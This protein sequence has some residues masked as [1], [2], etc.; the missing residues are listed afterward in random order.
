MIDLAL[1]SG[2]IG[3]FLLAPSQAPVPALQ[4]LPI[5]ALDRL[6][7]EAQEQVAEQQR[8]LAALLDEPDRDERE[9][10]EGFGELGKL[11]Y[12]YGLSDL[13]RI[14]WS[15]ASAIA[16][17]DFRWHY[18]LGVLD[19]LEGDLESAQANFGRVLEL[20][21]GDVPARIR[22]ARLDLERGRLE[23][24]AS[25]FESV[26]ESLPDSGAAL[27]G[28]GRIALARERYEEAIGFLGRA[29]TGQGEGSVIHHQLGLAYRGLGDL[30]SARGHLGRNRGVA[31]GF[32]DPVM[33][34]LVP[35][36]QGAHF[37]ARLGIQALQSGDPAG[38]VVGLERAAGIDPESAWIRYNLA[39]AYREAGRLEEAQSEFLAALERDRDYRNAHF[40]LGTLLAAQGDYA[41]A[42]RH[43]A[44]ASEIDPLDHAARLEL[45]VAASRLGQTERA[46]AEIERLVA[47]AP[48]WV[49]ARLALATLLGSQGRDAEALAV[50]TAS[51][52]LDATLSERSAVHTLVGRLLESS[53]PAAAQDHFRSAIELSPDAEEARF[54]LALMLG[55]SRDFADSAAEFARLV[56]SSPENPDYLLGHGM[57]LLLAESYAPARE[58][59]ERGRAAFPQN[60][61]FTHSLARLLASCPDDS[62]R[63][64]ARSLELARSVLQIRQTLPHAET[65]AMA[66][67]AVGR[68]EAAVEVQ[69]R[70]IEEREQLGAGRELEISRS[71]LSR[72]LAATP[73][74][75]PWRGGGP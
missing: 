16:A 47:E 59:L 23:R 29:L 62:V 19:R 35:L 27:A 61:S 66:L 43:F 32:F 3:L 70:V 7:V 69:R 38:A 56:R 4:P 72:Y 33:E 64:G 31:V 50:A 46:T 22:S 9:L 41:G 18:Y 68:F 25:G 28:L 12:V 1:A 36:V 52:S 63:D 2:L 45:A 24:A 39:V 55:R 71:Y 58:V 48:Q 34:Q 44:R 67:A 30:E 11:Y 40:N 51:L 21:P 75:A 20:R 8:R 53:S 6:P 17:Q 37:H 60:L 57:A 74:R 14:A 73:V 15:N 26:L 54:R 65:M 10:A 42:A 49:E 13:A 5:A